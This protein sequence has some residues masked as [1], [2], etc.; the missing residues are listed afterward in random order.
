MKTNYSLHDFTGWRDTVTFLKR[1]PRQL[2]P[3]RK[4]WSLRKTCEDVASEHKQAARCKSCAAFSSS[5][6]GRQP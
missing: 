5:R 2:R 3:G 4:Y 1:S 6:M